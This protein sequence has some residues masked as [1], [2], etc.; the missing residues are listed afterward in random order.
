MFPRYICLHHKLLCLPSYA[1]DGREWARPITDKCRGSHGP[2]DSTAHDLL[3]DKP[4]GQTRM[5]DT[6][7]H[8]RLGYRCLF[9]ASPP[10]ESSNTKANLE[11]VPGSNFITWGRY[12]TWRSPEQ[13][14]GSTHSYAKTE[15]YS[16]DFGRRILTERSTVHTCPR[17]RGYG[18][19]LSSDL[20]ALAR[21]REIKYQHCRI[22]ERRAVSR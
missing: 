4:A 14:C 9:P 6:R 18:G 8:A 21:P 12:C 1:F 19:D 13:I 22:G 2:R 3:Q 20:S 11:R 15:M 16:G 17:W 5:L 10:P 7:G